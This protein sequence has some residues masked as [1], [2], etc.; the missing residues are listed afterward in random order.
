MPI[1]RKVSSFDTVTKTK[2]VTATKTKMTLRSVP[3]EYRTYT[4]TV[5]NALGL[6]ESEVTIKFVKRLPSLTVGIAYLE[7]S[8][9]KILLGR[10]RNDTLF[11]IA[12]E[13]RHIW[14][15]KTN[16]MTIKYDYINK[17]K[18]S[19]AYGEYITTMRIQ[20]TYIWTGT[21]YH[22]KPVT[23]KRMSY[24][25]KPQEV[26]ANGFATYSRSKFLN[27]KLV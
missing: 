25:N 22:P 21:E 5:M 12:H 8:T 9:V 15:F 14:Q 20:R 16:T 7:Q 2:P 6:K 1:V 11:T 26:D 18:Y 4:E 10:E 27:N 13:L 19:R 3:A 17:R 24:D 23:T